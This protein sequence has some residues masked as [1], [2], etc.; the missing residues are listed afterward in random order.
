MGYFSSK[1]YARALRNQGS[2]N[3]NQAAENNT[4]SLM[5]RLLTSRLI[6][7]RHHSTACIFCRSHTG[8]ERSTP[9]V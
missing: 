8:I 7:E 6:A 1:S 2:W 3:G 9:A 5:I 4:V